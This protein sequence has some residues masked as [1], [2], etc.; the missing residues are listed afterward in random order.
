MEV[1]KLANLK[2]RKEKRKF[3]QNDF[4]FKEILVLFGLGLCLI[5]LTMFIFLT[6]PAPYSQVFANALYAVNLPEHQ[7]RFE[8]A[9][10]DE[11][12]SLIE[13]NRLECELAQ[14]INYKIENPWLCEVALNWPFPVSVRYFFNHD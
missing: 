1:Q 10:S 5:S 14:D 8:E 12:L 7:K 13:I 11:V 9:I 2:Q 4:Y 3:Y 6:G